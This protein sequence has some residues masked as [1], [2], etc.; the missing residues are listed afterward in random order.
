MWHLTPLSSS[1]SC[2]PCEFY[3]PPFWDKMKCGHFE[4]MLLRSHHLQWCPWWSCW[5]CF[6]SMNIFTHANLIFRYHQHQLPARSRQHDDVW[7]NLLEH[8]SHPNVLREGSRCLVNLTARRGP[9]LGMFNNEP[10]Y[11]LCHLEKWS[12]SLAI[13]T[14][15]HSLCIVTCYRNII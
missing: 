11:V 5:Y 14:H 9:R 7:P 12:V 1:A 15:F 8:R 2:H 6:N 4:M 13:G 10:K 3:K